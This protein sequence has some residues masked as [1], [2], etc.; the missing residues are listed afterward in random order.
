MAQMG[1]A[2]GGDAGEW[3]GVDGVHVGSAPDEDGAARGARG[4]QENLE[5]DKVEC[6]K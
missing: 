5:K 3:A 6:K 1:G 2:D 4:N